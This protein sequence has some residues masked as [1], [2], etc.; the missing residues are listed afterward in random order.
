MKNKKRR[1]AEK[2]IGLLGSRENRKRLTEE[3][4]KAYNTPLLSTLVTSAVDETLDSL[5]TAYVDEY[6]KR[7]S[8]KLL[9]ALVKFYRSPVGQEFLKTG[10]KLDL[11]LSHIGNAW[12][13]AVLQT[14]VNEYQK[15]MLE[16]KLNSSIAPAELPPMGTKL[17]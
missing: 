13:E 14:A 15:L 7:C 4:V 11:E 10:P 8:E 2:L 12:T 6:E 9:K 1:L 17:H 3:L 16:S 5:M